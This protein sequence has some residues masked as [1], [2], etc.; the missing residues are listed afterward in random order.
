[1]GGVPLRTGDVVQ[2][3]IAGSTSTKIWSGTNAPNAVAVDATN[4][5]VLQNNDL[6]RVP[7][8][9]GTGATLATG[10]S[11]YGLA[12]TGATVLWTT[13]NGMD[14]VLSVPANGG[15]TSTFATG[16]GAPGTSSTVVVTDGTNVY[17]GD[18]ASGATSGSVY[19]KPLVGGQQTTLYQGPIEVLGIAFDTT[20]LYVT[21][22]Q[23]GVVL[24]IPKAG[25]Q[26]TTLASGQGW[27]YGI[28]V[29]ETFVYWVNNNGGANAVMRIA[30]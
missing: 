25:G 21:G 28:A 23:A 11:A 15:T 10:Q 8:G 18:T 4:V 12:V 30:K 3:T 27:P 9:G 5:Y 14:T 24:K 20:Y 1:M 29:D 16:S 17:W 2:T 19:A 13:Y 22:G 7:I 26:P 6:E